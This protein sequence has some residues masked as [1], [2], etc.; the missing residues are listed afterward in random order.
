M[1]NFDY[2]T[3]AESMKEQAQDLVPQEFSEEN[4]Q[5]LADMLYNFTL[6]SG[7]TLAKEGEL[8]ENDAIMLVQ[9]ISEWTFHKT[10]DLVRSQVPKEHWDNILQHIAFKIFEFGKKL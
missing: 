8:K 4:K 6:M 3:F 2:K 9:I 1:T 7:E 10:C 5:Y